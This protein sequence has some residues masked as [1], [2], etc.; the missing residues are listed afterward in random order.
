M[1][2]TELTI[3]NYQ[4]ASS[5]IMAQSLVDLRR[6]IHAA[7]L[8]NVNVAMDG[9]E[10]TETEVNAMTLI[11]EL[12]QT[13]GLDLAAVLMRADL[14]RQIERTN[15]ITNHPAG[16]RNLQEMANDQGIS[17]SELSNTLDWVNVIF[18]F[19]Q[20]ELGLPVAQFFERVG[21]SNLR[22]LTPILK[23]IITGEPSS[24]ASV[25]NSVERLLEDTA[26][27]L[28]AAGSGP[29]LGEQNHPAPEGQDD[30][31]QRT[32]RAT[33]EH[34]IE[35]GELLP[36]RELRRTVR[37][38][39]TPVIQGTALRGANGGQI[40][41]LAS[42]T[43]EQYQS[44]MRRASSVLDLSNI[45]VDGDPARRRELLPRVIEV[46]RLLSLMEG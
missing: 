42:M 33:V 43:E 25:R 1:T 18:P 6:S 31:I 29:E 14:L 5:E 12:R 37:P 39:R 24:T 41:V 17:V 13:N 36:N 21:K 23:S 22:E 8:A 7:A 26:A 19:V 27:S 40:M 30:F 10:F 28:L 38:E 32:R 16:Y 3:M 46:R 34:L 45:E 4:P 9:Q 11:E 35:Q 2:D 15:A 44:L 20:D